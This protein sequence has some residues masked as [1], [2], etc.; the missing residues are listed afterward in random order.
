MYERAEYRK[1]I[2]QGLIS[3]VLLDIETRGQVFCK[4]LGPVNICI[5]IGTVVLVYLFY[6]TG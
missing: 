2:F 6:N 4:A 1:P 3:R 5:A